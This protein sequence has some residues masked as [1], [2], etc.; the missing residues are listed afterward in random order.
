MVKG[1]DIDREIEVK[2][3]RRKEV[4]C[5]T[6][7]EDRLISRAKLKGE[8]LDAVLVWVEGT[9]GELKRRK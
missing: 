5:C 6:A 7:K 9:I 2:E 1:Y 3:A 4:G 8:S